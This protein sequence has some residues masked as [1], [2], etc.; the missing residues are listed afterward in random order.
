MYRD[1]LYWGYRTDLDF[2]LRTFLTSVVVLVAGYWFFVRHSA[3]FS[4]EV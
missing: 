4:E 2:F 1:L 3:N